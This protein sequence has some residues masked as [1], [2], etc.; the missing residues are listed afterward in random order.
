MDIWKHLSQKRQGDKEKRD[1][2]KQGLMGNSGWWWGAGDGGCSQKG[3]Y[4]TFF[5]FPQYFLSLICLLFFKLDPEPRPPCRAFSPEEGRPWP[6]VGRD[7]RRGSA[8][9]VPELDAGR[10]RRRERGSRWQREAQWRIWHSETQHGTL[11]DWVSKCEKQWRICWLN[12]FLD[13]DPAVSKN[14]YNTR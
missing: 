10:G 3:S 1:V 2:W 5:S 13:L 4:I 9:S 7:G 14:T 8:C 11:G 6:A 12:H